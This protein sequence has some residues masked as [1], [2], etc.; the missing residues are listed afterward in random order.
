[1]RKLAHGV[2]NLGEEERSQLEMQV[3][4]RA[5]SRAEAEL[6]FRAS[7][8]SRT[9]DRNLLR[10]LF[11][12]T[13]GAESPDR[14]AANPIPAPP[15]DDLLSSAYKTQAKHSSVTVCT[16]AFFEK[17]SEARLTEAQRRYPEL[18]KVSGAPGGRGT[19][20]LPPTKKRSGTTTSFSCTPPAQSSLSGGAA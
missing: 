10:K 1:M 3:K 6:L 4:T 15:E 11:V 13:P 9:K 7:E 5:R 19:F 20:V 18:M 17:L 8:G 16:D 2:G 12:Q 14:L